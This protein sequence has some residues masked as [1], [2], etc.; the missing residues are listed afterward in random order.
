MIEYPVNNV[1]EGKWNDAVPTQFQKL[2]PH[3]PD[4]QH[5]TI[6]RLKNE[7]CVTLQRLENGLTTKHSRSITASVEFFFIYL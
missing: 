3:E 1:L 2:T 4:G 7:V 6:R 5:K